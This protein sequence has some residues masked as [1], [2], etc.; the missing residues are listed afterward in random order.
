V[1]IN[2]ADWK[3]HSSQPVDAQA[4]Q[5]ALISKPALLML[6]SLVYCTKRSLPGVFSTVPAAIKPVRGETAISGAVS[7]VPLYILRKSKL[8][9]VANVFRVTA[10][11]PLAH[12]RCHP[13]V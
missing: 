10:T 6:K 4:P 9:S 12:C 5:V 11:H 1:S 2:P 7:S 8:F 13:Q 3:G